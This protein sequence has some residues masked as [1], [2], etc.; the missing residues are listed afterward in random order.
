MTSWA[1]R[2]DPILSTAAAA[3]DLGC[4]RNAA[5]AIQVQSLLH[6]LLSQIGPW[7]SDHNSFITG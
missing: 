4:A 7:P 5:G 1:V 6:G 2:A 3:A